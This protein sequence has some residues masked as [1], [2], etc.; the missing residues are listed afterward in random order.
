MS[1]QNNSNSAGTLRTLEL[2]A[3]VG[4]FRLGLEAVQGSPFKIVLSN[5][6]EPSRKK[7]HAS[8]IYQARWPGC[9]HINED[10]FKVLE[11][12]AGAQAIADASPEVVVGGFPC[13]DFS[14]AKPL[15]KSLG[16]A[17]KKGVLWWA[18]TKLLQQ[19]IEDAEPVKYLI[20]ENV[21]RLLSS[22]ASCRG[23]DFSVILST[24]YSLGYAVE[25]RTI[26]AAE[27]GNAQRRRRVFIVGYHKSTDVYRKLKSEGLATDGS[28]W[29]QH[30]ILNEA[31]PC[32]PR[33]PLDGVAPAL[34]LRSDPFDEQLRYQPL[35]SGKSRFSNCGLMLDGDVRTFTVDAAD[36]AD[37]SEFTGHAQPLTLADII[38]K[39]G[40]VPTAF[41]IK[42]RDE[43]K[44]RAAKAAKSVPRTTN[45]FT[46]NYSEGA[47][48]F[49]DPLDR[50]ARTII[51]SEG[52]T[53]ATRTKHAIRETGGLIRRLVPE[54]LE[55]LNG[56]PRGFT[57]HPG[58]SDVTRAL[59]MGNALVV[60]LV[61][62][63][64]EALYKTHLNNQHI[65]GN[66]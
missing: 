44:W 27:Y 24:L 51:T 25:W 34:S 43:D 57:A 49:P 28:G 6:F 55:A 8:E 61:R 53:T 4:G 11:S 39:T 45:G 10:I 50:P 64:G 36:I 52:G 38:S 9:P 54:E 13:Q 42:P 5:Q 46:Y 7:Q 12:E 31:L 21:D 48:L 26:N 66:D 62:R 29:L 17:G 18:I 3:G 41:Y 33:N 58:V 63:I 14:I 60:P 30:T 20:L 35:S 47:M 15:S 37:F 16:L 59:L 2:F 56:F 23:R 1:E 65:A 19:R 22:P 40:P 32:V